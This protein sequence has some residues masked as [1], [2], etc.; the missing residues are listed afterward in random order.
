MS[1]HAPPQLLHIA[2]LSHQERETLQL[3]GEGHTAKSIAA[4]TGRS[5][6]SV[7]ESLRRARQK[8]GF[9]SSRELAR[10][11]LD[12]K[13][14]DEQIGL[15]SSAEPATKR[16]TYLVKGAMVMTIATVV[17]TA[18]ALWMPAQNAS[19]PTNDPLLIQLMPQAN[20]EPRVLAELVRSEDRDVPWA[21]QAE[22]TL[23]QKYS[24]LIG[25]DRIELIRVRCGAT[26]CEAAGRL[27]VRDPAR[28][29]ATMQLLQGPELNREALQSSLRHVAV[30]FGT[31]HVFATY[32]IRER[33]SH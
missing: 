6:S 17:I 29:N 30:T 16:P 25:D 28:V 32:W 8:T 31:E 20:Q 2:R 14:V 4:R 11:L 18:A 10:R 1:I 5:F 27:R 13:I 22:A 33:I 26:V 7:N 15:S 12:E 23:R 9:G 24:P 3:L 21:D 19:Q